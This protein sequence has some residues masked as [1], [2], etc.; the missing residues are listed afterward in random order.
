MLCRMLSI[1]CVLHE[2]ITVQ[3]RAGRAHRRGHFLREDDS[4]DR[5][6][7]ISIELFIYI[8]T[9]KEYVL[10]IERTASRCVFQ[11]CV[12]PNLILLW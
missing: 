8:V 2:P 3:G 10:V 4:C 12:S 11:R 7:V 1:V 9:T 5:T 6:L